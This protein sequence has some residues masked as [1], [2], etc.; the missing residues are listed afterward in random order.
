[1]LYEVFLILLVLPTYRF[2]DFE[3]EQDVQNVIANKNNSELNGSSLRLLPAS[4][5]GNN[6][7][8]GL[9]R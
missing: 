5:G 9:S 8:S 3:T 1:M 7:S 2:V 4:G 6:R